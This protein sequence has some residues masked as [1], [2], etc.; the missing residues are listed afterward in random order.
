[1]HRL[2]KQYDCY[3]IG[4]SNRFLASRSHCSH[5]TDERSTHF[6]QIP[7]YQMNG[8]H[9]MNTLMQ[10]QSFIISVDLLFRECKRN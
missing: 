1:M 3:Y 10:I 5:Y 9:L 4:W 7:D 6:V 2:L 8:C